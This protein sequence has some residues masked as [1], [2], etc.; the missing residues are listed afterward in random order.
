M[1]YIGVR[2]SIN[3]IVHIKIMW[4]RKYLCPYLIK[5]NRSLE[6]A[7]CTMVEQNFTLKY[8]S[9]SL[10]ERDVLATLRSERPVALVVMVDLTSH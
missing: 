4:A 7:A 9:R 2:T 6:A 5:L 10:W 8:K 1:E 3:T